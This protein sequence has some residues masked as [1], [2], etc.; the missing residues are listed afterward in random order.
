MMTYD[1]LNYLEEEIKRGETLS[2]LILL[3]LINTLRELMARD[4]PYP[5]SRRD[6]FAGM[7][8]GHVIPKVDSMKLSPEYF[9]KGVVL[10]SVN[11]ADAMIAE[12]DKEGK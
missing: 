5:L 2:T 7:V 6:W 1:Q 11:I 4:I 8:M 9:L 3:E 10:T 12:L